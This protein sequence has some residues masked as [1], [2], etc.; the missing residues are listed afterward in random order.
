MKFQ[1]CILKHFERTHGRTKGRTD[2]PIAVC[3]FN[4]YKVG[5][6]KHFLL[7]VLVAVILR[8]NTIE[9]NI[10]IKVVEQVVVPLPP[11]WV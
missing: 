3:P 10:G 4:L 6:I 7:S 5:D 2:N 1:N 11:N 9:Q 8:I